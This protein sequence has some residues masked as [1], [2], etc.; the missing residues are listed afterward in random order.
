MPKPNVQP[1][2]RAS[3]DTTSSC[4]DS[5]TSAAFR[6]IPWRTAGGVC[7]HSANAAAAASTARFASARVAG[8]DLRDD[9]A[10]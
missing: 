8:G 10:A 5:S 4:L 7:D 9:V 1:V 3:I 2:S 6:K